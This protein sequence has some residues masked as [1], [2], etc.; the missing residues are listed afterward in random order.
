MGVERVLIGPTQG[1]LDFIRRGKALGDATCCSLYVAVT[2][3]RASLAF[4]VADPSLFRMP[5]WV[6]GSD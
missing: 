2:R 5:K 6:P 3:A 4:A 1:M